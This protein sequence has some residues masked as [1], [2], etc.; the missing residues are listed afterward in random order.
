MSERRLAVKAADG[1]QSSAYDVLSFSDNVDKV[2]PQGVQRSDRN[3]GLQDPY[4]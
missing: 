1:A 2:V 4:C 3:I